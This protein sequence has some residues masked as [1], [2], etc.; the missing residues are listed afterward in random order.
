MSGRWMRLDNAALIFPAVRRQEW[1]NVFRESVTLTEPVDPALLQRAVEDLQPRFPSLFV[2]LRTGAFWYYLEEVAAPPKVRQDY[3][4][5]LAHMGQRELGT[6]C[7]RVLY[8]KN[9]IAVEF[10]HSLTDGSGALVFL[11][12]LAARYIT[13]RYSVRVPPEHGVLDCRDEPDPEELEDSFQRYS[14]PYPMSRAEENSYRLRGTREFSG[15]RHLTTGVIPTGRLLD[16]A[17]SYHVTVT[18]FLAAVMA[19]SILSMQAERVPLSRQKPVK[20]TIPVNLRWLFPSRTLRNFALTVNPGVDPRLGSYTLQEL[21]SAISH[22]LAAEVTPQKMAGRIAAN[23]QPQRKAVMKLAPVFLKNAALRMIYAAAGECKGCLNISNLGSVELPEIMGSYVERLEFI[24][25][26]Q[27]TYP[28]NCSVVSYGE[29]T[30]INMIR[31]I[32][33]SELERRF[34]SRLVELGVPVCI[35]SNS[36]GDSS[37]TV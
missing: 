10:F 23:V 20:I 9:R 22:Q 21:C 27:Y 36:R 6:C 4:Y 25:G 32:R 5:P 17:H 18:A 2:R 3:A 12:S 13:L 28:N 16:A 29:T 33:E 24:I 26:V 7:L 14:G 19:E 34:F 11:K 37:C 8:Y 30:C 1:N 35:E 15:L 31:N